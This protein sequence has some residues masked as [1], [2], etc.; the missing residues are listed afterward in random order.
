MTVF[1]FSFIEM[2]IDAY[3]YLFLRYQ[4]KHTLETCYCCDIRTFIVRTLKVVSTTFLDISEGIFIEECVGQSLL[5]EQ[6][7]KYKIYLV[8]GFDLQHKGKLRSLKIY[9]LQLTCIK[10]YVVNVI[11]YSSFLLF[12]SLSCVH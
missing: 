1:P 7:Q 9:F 4:S 11:A 10:F 2:W 8:F 5:F 3:A 12:S 6:A